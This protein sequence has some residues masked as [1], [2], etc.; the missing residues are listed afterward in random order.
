L[1][2]IFAFGIGILAFIAT[3]IDDLFV[4]MLFFSSLSYHKW[5]VVVGQYIGIGALVAVSALGSLL[6]LLVP[7]YVIGLLGI[8]PIT[9]GVIRLL[10]LRN[11]SYKSNEIKMP[12][13]KWHNHLSILTVASVTFSNGGDNIGIYT[14]LFAKYN[15]AFEVIYI[16]SIFMI[17]T[18]VWCIIAYYLVRHPLIATRMKKTGYIIFPLV[19]IGLGIYI[20]LTSLI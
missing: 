2:D 14:P 11:N 19:L 20:I 3:D 7:E 13:S 1:T 5:Q 6:S 10:H 17:M 12:V 8:V 15:S 9:I 16:S 4:L 18:A